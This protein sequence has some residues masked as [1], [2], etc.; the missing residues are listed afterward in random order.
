MTKSTD[1]KMP[2]LNEL[3]RQGE[4]VSFDENQTPVHTDTAQTL[5]L[6]TT[7]AGVNFVSE[8]IRE[9]AQQQG[10][11]EERKAALEQRAYSAV[12][13]RFNNNAGVILR[14]VNHVDGL[15]IDATSQY[16][17][18][19]LEGGFWKLTNAHEFNVFLEALEVEGRWQDT[20]GLQIGQQ[21]TLLH[22]Q[23]TSKIDNF[24]PQLRTNV[25]SEVIDIAIR[26]VDAKNRTA[27]AVTGHLI[28]LAEPLDGKAPV[29]PF[30][31][32][33]YYIG[34]SINIEYE[35]EQ[36]EIVTI[37]KALLR[38]RVGRRLNKIKNEQIHPK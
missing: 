36:G 10:Y 13:R 15:P 37:N 26:A 29:E 12:E 3:K 20:S 22:E 1:K 33:I 16:G 34:T 23:P 27:K 2:K 31:G 18:S 17:N 35:N 28:K 32:K 6:I 19:D 7:V 21:T 25:L 14:L 11:S 24:S 4:W 5:A 30:T 9:F 38:K 8:F